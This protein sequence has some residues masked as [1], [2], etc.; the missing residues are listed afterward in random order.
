MNRE[1]RFGE[2]Y[3]LKDHLWMDGP[4]GGYLALDR[5]MGR[6]V[7]INYPYRTDDSLFLEWA[8]IRARL[9]HTNLIPVYDFGN[10]ADGTPFFTEPHIRALPLWMWL[11]HDDAR[12]VITLPCLVACLRN[13]CQAIACLHANGLVHLGID[14][15][16]VVVVPASTEVFVGVGKYPG[17]GPVYMD[18]GIGRFGVTSVPAYMDY[19]S[20][21]EIRDPDVRTDV[22]GLGGMLFEMLYDEP[23]NGRRHPLAED[24]L[25][26]PPGWNRP[27]P[28]GARA[29][30]YRGLAHRLEPI[31]LRA[32]EHDRAARQ[33]SVSAFIDEIDGA[34]IG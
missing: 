18:M 21:E 32:L 28:L 20:R 11:D 25:T 13:A 5:I 8:Q 6:D 9:R 3:A 1:D 15:N 30:R 23:P 17:G 26:P 2:R 27:P 19:S 10:A 34:S 12:P 29:A 24:D 14:T 4:H 22:Y 16:N 33:G 31:C 7:V